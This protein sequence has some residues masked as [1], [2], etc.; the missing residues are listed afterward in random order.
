MGFINLSGV[1]FWRGIIPVVNIY[2]LAK[3]LQVNIVYIILITLCIIF[4]P[5]RMLFVTA[6][7]LILPFAISYTYDGG[8]IGGIL[9]I[10]APFI[11]YPYLAFVKRKYNEE[12]FFSK[13]FVIFVVLFAIACVVFYLFFR[14]IEGNKLIDKKSPYYYNDLYMSDGRIY[15]KLTK[16]QKIMYDDMVKAYKTNNL[17]FKIDNSK[18]GCF[19]LNACLND[20]FLAHDAIY[21]DHPE[22]LSASGISYERVEGQETGTVTLS[23]AL[24]AAFLNDIFISRIE[25]M[26]DDVKY[27]TKDMSDKEK[28][29]YVYKYIDKLA[30]YDKM[31]MRTAKNQSAYNV[32][33]KGNAVCAGFAKTA[34]LLFQNIGIE[35]YSVIGVTSGRHMWNIVKYEGKY[36]YFDATVAVSLTEDSPYYY[37]GLDQEKMN[38]YTEEQPTWN[39]QVETTRMFD[40]TDEDRAMQVK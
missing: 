2:Y 13:H 20:I 6:I 40:L 18:Y 24:E 3:A 38:S 37:D 30:Y 32:F 36:Y 5:F 10:I 9:A 33:I 27:A 17:T 16:Y 25:R 7:V 39:P 1:P 14:P 34:Q 4:L 29:I 23:N 11:V 31:F 35:S 19:S 21:I 8:F 26:I 28:I 12:N 15:K 22:I